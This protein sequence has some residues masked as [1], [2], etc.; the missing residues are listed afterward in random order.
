MK[1]EVVVNRFSKGA[2]TVVQAKPRQSYSQV[3]RD[4]LTRAN[5]M[6]KKEVMK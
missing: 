3:K 5:A 1:R 4:T 6:F 2:E